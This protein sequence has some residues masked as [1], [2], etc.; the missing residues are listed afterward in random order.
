MS[1][2]AVRPGD[3]ARHHISPSLLA[4]LQRRERRR[5]WL[6]A[7]L[8]AAVP[9]ALVLGLVVVSAHLRA[10]DDNVSMTPIAPTASIAAGS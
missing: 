10:A 1:I 6:Y 5:R 7:G 3:N 9:V 4:F 8:Q 2:R